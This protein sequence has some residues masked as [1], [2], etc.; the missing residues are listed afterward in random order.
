MR[1]GVIPHQNYLNTT[2]DKLVPGSEVI[3]ESGLSLALEDSTGPDHMLL[4]ATNDNLENAGFFI[5]E[6]TRGDQMLLES[7]ET[8][9]ADQSGLI[10]FNGTDSD[11]TDA[12]DKALLE[13]ATRSDVLNNSAFTVAGVPRFDKTEILF[14]STVFDMSSV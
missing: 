4:D 8:D 5:L 3:S 13:L 1:Q 14:D 11:S 10:L 6:E 7:T 9:F 12:G 2:F